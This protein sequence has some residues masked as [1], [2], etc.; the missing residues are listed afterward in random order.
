MSVETLIVAALSGALV[1]F[2]IYIGFQYWSKK[3]KS[4][5]DPVKERTH[6]LYKDIFRYKSIEKVQK[7]LMI[8]G[9]ICAS[10]AVILFWPSW[11]AFVMAI[12]A[13]Y[14]GWKIPLLFLEKIVLQKRINEFTTQMID[15]LTLMGNGMRSG[16]NFAQAIQIVVQEMPSPVKD[17]FGLVL[18]ENKL[19]LTI[20]QALD[21]M[22]KRLPS[23]DVGVFVTSVNI[24]RET[25]GNLTET[26]DTITGTL[27]QRIKLNNKIK[28]M[29]AQGKTQAV[30]VGALPWVLAGVLFLLAPD[31]IRPL[32]TTVLG[33]IV[34]LMVCVLEGIGIFMILKMV[35]IKV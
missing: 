33:F 7:E 12:F 1:F 14:L 34:L 4:K 26:F 25:G 2:S 35:D 23:D 30:I 20:E 21:N 27:R 31:Q 16:L 8:S 28:A 13:F 5:L 3:I 6:Q 29:T 15:A 18:S 11:M 32:F 19:G 9:I 10:L 17:E 22:A 24:L